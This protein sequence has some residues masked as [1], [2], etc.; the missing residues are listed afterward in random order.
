VAGLGIVAPDPDRRYY[1]ETG[2][3][4]SYGFKHYWDANGGLA[5]FGYPLTTEFRELNPAD[6]KEYTVQYFQRARFEY[7]PEHKGTQFEVLLGLLGNQTTADRSFNAP[8][9]SGPPR[10]GARYFP[11]TKQW[12]SGPLL[13]HWTQRGGLMVYGYPISP[14]IEEINPDDGKTYRVQYFER[15]RLEY[16]SEHQGTPH[17]VLLGLLG[18]QVLVERGWLSR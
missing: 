11:E 15:N 17:E 10:E 5:Q 9:T 1:P 6:G 7:H 4:L 13:K 3:Y 2:H 14:E 12:V 8:P 16:H 18:R